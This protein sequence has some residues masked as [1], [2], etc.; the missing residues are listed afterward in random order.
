MN[1]KNIIIGVLGVLCCVLLAALTINSKAS[2]PNDV[3]AK[4]IKNNHMPHTEIIKNALI[5]GLSLETP[6]ENIDKLIAKIPFECRT[7]ERETKN[8]EG[9]TKQEKFWR[10]SHKIFKGAALRLDVVDNKIKSIIR[11]GPSTKKDIEDAITQLDHL[12]LKLKNY[13]GF[14]FNQSERSTV[15]RLNHKKE[16]NTATSMSFRTQHLFV[17]KPDQK[18]EYDGMLNVALVR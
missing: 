6:V 12:K 5:Y 17:N 9:K 1:N 2:Q 8:K 18:P 14:V 11:N 7:S 10:C 13:K 4:A 3:V 16:D 15:F